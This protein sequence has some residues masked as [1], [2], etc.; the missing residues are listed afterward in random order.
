[1]SMWNRSEYLVLL[2]YF[3]E[4]DIFEEKLFVFKANMTAK[5]DVCVKQKLVLKISLDKVFPL[6][7]VNT[8]ENNEIKK[9]YIV[10]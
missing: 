4:F 3:Y 2:D 1:M 5:L 8:S 9:L 6:N 10:D 7:K